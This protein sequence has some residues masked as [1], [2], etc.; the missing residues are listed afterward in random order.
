MV[1]AQYGFFSFS[2]HACSMEV[3]RV[4][5]VREMGC[6]EGHDGKNEKKE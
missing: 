1:L 4:C 2:A 3:L 6:R 5:K